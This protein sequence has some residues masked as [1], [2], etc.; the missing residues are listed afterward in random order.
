HLREEKSFDG[1][2]KLKAQIQ[3]DIEAAKQLIS[4]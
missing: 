4:Q 2:E 1:L 3:R